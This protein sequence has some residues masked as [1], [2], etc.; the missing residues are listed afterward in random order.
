MRS[1][2]ERAANPGEPVFV[3]SPEHR[4]ED[5][6]VCLSVVL[7]AA[8]GTSFLL[9]LD[10][11]D[12]GELARAEVPPTTCRSASTGSSCAAADAGRGRHGSGK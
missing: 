5:D 2:G 6:G 7:D 8:R 10:A 11:A 3:P 1:Y 9:V 4:G 12:F